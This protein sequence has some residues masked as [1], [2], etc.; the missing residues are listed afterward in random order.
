MACDPSR[1]AIDPGTE[2]APLDSAAAVCEGTSTKTSTRA[3]RLLALLLFSSLAAVAQQQSKPRD[4]YY[5]RAVYTKWNPGKRSEGLAFVNDVVQKAAKSWAEK[6]PGAVGQIT[7]SRVLPGGSEISHDRLRLTIYS[8]PPDLGGADN[9]GAAPYVESTGMP[10]AEFVAKLG[11]LYETVRTEVW[12]SVIRHGSI[13]L[14]DYVRVSWYKVDSGYMAPRLAYL[15]TWIDPMY[16]ELANRGYPRRAME[17]WQILFAREE[18][19]SFTGV[20]AYPD[21][22]ALYAPIGFKRLL[23]VFESSHTQVICKTPHSMEE[24]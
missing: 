8:T 4:R 1:M 20:T 2:P 12:Q 24:S 23:V 21:S 9:P 6:H 13:R 14:G 18:E 16:A 22:A 11:T 19:P 5:A 3:K 15:R 7:M 17:S 10:Q